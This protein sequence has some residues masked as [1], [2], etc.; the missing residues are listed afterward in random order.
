V[1]KE[2]YYEKVE[3]ELQSFFALAQN[4]ISHLLYLQSKRIS[5]KQLPYFPTDKAH[6]TYNAHPK[7]FYIH[8]EVQVTRT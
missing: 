3:A 2:N 1:L 4:F 7:L 5:N 6:L 8:F